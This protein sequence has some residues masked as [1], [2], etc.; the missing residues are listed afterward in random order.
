[1]AADRQEV[2]QRR[3]HGFVR[4]ADSNVLAEPRLVSQILS[5]QKVLNAKKPADGRSECSESL[6]RALRPLALHARLSRRVTFQGHEPTRPSVYGSRSSLSLSGA[7]PPS[8][9]P[10][11][12]LSLPTVLRSRARR[13]SGTAGDC[14]RTPWGWRHVRRLARLLR[15]QHLDSH[16]Q[17]RRG[18]AGEPCLH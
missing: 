2:C 4:R 10:L 9:I 16:I 14:P 11:H 15:V 1:M 17:Q 5:R 13:D 7:P 12:T 3:L 8:S 18:S 6:S